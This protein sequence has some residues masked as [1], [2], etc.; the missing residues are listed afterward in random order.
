MEPDQ[1]MNG[2]SK[3]IDQ[4]LKLMSKAKTPE[5]KLTYSESVKNL[6]ESLGVFLNL[7]A[8]MMPYDDDSDDPIPF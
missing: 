4:I 3:E 8:D 7:M 1:I 2:I 6:C 5:E